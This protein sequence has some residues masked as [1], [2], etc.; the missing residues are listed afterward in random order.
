MTLQ[1]LLEKK[2][3]KVKPIQKSTKILKSTR[4]SKSQCPEIS[5]LKKPLDESEGGVRKLA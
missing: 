4:L 2:S 1:F 5:S 3:I